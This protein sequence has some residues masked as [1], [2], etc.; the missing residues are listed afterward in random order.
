[1]AVW[2]EPEDAPASVGAPSG[3]A[4]PNVAPALDNPWKWNGKSRRTL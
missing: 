2:A 3:F 4:V 1:M